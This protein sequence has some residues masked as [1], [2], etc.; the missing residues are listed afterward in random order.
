MEQHHLWEQF[1][2]QWKVY[3]ASHY[4]LRLVGTTWAKQTLLQKGVVELQSSAFSG[5][6]VEVQGVGGVY[7]HK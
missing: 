6:F 7:D 2:S 1:L 4:P 3:I 5:E